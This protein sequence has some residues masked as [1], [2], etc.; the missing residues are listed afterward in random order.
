MTPSDIVSGVADANELDDAFLRRLCDAGDHSRA[1][2]EIVRRFGPE[3]LGLLVALHRDTD[4]ASEAYSDF[5]ER[6]WTA[7]PRFEWRSSVRTWAYVL[8][9]RA[10]LDRRRNEGRRRRRLQPLAIS[11]ELDEIAARVRTETLDALRTE[12][13]QALVELRASLPEP[14]QILLVLRVDRALAWDDLARVFL[15]EDAPPPESLQREAARLRKRF[16]LVRE[17]LRALG[18]ERGLLGDG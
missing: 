8:A 10:S 7:L 6:M 2:A 4:E 12:S 5:A 18:R 16:Q 15:G 9:R 14:D 11:P 3:I 1:A 17:R 13:R